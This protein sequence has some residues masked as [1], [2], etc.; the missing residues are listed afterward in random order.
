M[1]ELDELTIESKICLIPGNSGILFDLKGSEATEVVLV[2]MYI[3]TTEYRLQFYSLHYTEGFLF[4]LVLIF[5]LVT[6]TTALSFLLIVCYS[7][8][9]QS[10]TSLGCR[11]KSHSSFTLLKYIKIRRKEEMNE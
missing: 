8:P 10:R 5:L 6:E 9:V 1:H 2:R 7:S 11:H 4:L 3:L